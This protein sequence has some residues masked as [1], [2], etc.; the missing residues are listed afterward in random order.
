MPIA[1]SSLLSAKIVKGARLK[2]YSGA[3]HGL[4]ATLK[5]QVNSELLAFFK[6]PAV[7]PSPRKAVPV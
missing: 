7:K 6:E 4:T 3:P 5:D 1:D 2:V